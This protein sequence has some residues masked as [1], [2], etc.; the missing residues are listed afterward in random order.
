[1]ILHLWQALQMIIDTA[2]SACIHFRLGTP[3]SYADAFLKLTEAGYLDS[4][5]GI[6]LTH[7]AAVGYSI[8]HAYEELDMH[9]VYKIALEGPSDLKTFLASINK[10][11]Q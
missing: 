8:V 4:T 5:L 10:K 2:L 7:A 11:L 3:V 9:K 6:R 1:M